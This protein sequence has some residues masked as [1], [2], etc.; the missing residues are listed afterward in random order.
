[1]GTPGEDARKDL[2]PA[3]NST[4][5]SATPKG[6]EVP[7]P[8]KGSELSIKSEKD[9]QGFQTPKKEK[10]SIRDLLIQSPIPKLSFKPGVDLMSKLNTDNN[11]GPRR[12]VLTNEQADY[13][14]NLFKGNSFD[15]NEKLEGDIKT[16]IE[17]VI[18]TTINERDK[19]WKKALTDWHRSL[20]NRMETLKNLIGTL[21][22][23]LETVQE[24]VNTV[25]KD[26][27]K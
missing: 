23:V 9:V 26:D 22:G 14:Y 6:E 5:V 27:S 24:S 18:E 25:I 16:W 7:P 2:T 4:L 17:N 20:S 12:S 3:F 1:M 15:L 10:P 19:D 13:L 11:T 8:E 21:P